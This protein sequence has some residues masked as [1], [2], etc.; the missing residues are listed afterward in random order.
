[1]KSLEYLALEDIR[2][3]RAEMLMDLALRSTR[4][5]IALDLRG[6]DEIE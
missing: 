6:L 3:G 4:E 2:S 5:E 1:M